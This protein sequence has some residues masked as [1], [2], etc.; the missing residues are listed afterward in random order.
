MQPSVKSSQEGLGEA[1]E[2]LRLFQKETNWEPQQRGGTAL[3]SPSLA[4]QME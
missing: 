4:T 2:L 3:H 1:A